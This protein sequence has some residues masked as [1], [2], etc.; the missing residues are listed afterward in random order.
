M[1]TDSIDTFLQGLA[2]RD[3]APGGGATAALHAAQGAALV[4]MV[5]RFSDGAKYAEHAAEIGAVLAEADELRGLALDLVERD[6][7]AFGA[8][9]AAYGLPKDTAEAKSARSR[10]IA[11]ALAEASRVPVQVIAV[12]DRVV[13]LAER[14]RPVGNRNVITDIAAAADA[15]RAAASTSRVNAEVNL[16]GVADPP[17]RDALAAAIAEAADVL[18]RADET[19]TAVREQIQR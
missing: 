2:S 4:A 17:P 18:H 10:A 14:L 12:A 15:A 6:A 11:A 5:A 3:P 7:T 1:R 13:G 16:P 8:V 19:T 9:G